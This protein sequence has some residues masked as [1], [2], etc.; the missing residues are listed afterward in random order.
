MAD[1]TTQDTASSQY[2]EPRNTDE[3]WDLVTSP[4]P[5]VGRARHLGEAL[6]N[7][8]M[9][10]PTDLMQSLRMQQSERDRGRQRP[11]GQILTELGLVSQD[12]LR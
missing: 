4:H 12:Q 5:V 10:Q 2:F 7:A 1:T 11:I 8:G 9:L 3:L 6:I